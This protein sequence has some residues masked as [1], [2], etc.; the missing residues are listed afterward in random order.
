MEISTRSWEGVG[1]TLL[2][3]TQRCSFKPSRG[4]PAAPSALSV[5]ELSMSS[6]TE[7]VGLWRER[8]AQEQAAA[9]RASPLDPRQLRMTREARI[10]T[11]IELALRADPRL[12]LTPRQGKSTTPRSSHRV[13]AEAKQSPRNNNPSS[14]PRNLGVQVSWAHTFSITYPSTRLPLPPFLSRSQL[15]TVP[16]S[17]FPHLLST[18]AQVGTPRRDIGSFSSRQLVE[19]G[20]QQ[21]NTLS[22]D[23]W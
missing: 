11:E 6:A 10:R 7:A 12:R 1:P 8:V 5:G 14:T 15:L 16:H 22:S 23:W 2:M 20:L 3:C 4:R 9:L 18:R 19:K 21:K 13:K 17:P